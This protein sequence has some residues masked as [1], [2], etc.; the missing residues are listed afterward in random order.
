MGKEY[1]KSKETEGKQIEDITKRS[2]YFVSNRKQ[3]KQIDQFLIFVFY[4]ISE[5]GICNGL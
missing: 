1:F 5:G 2:K 4:N 3:N